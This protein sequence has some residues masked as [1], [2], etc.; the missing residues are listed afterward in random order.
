MPI[1]SFSCSSCG[2]EKDHL[3]KISQSVPFCPKCGSN[4]YKKQLTSASFSMG[5]QDKTACGADMKDIKE[6]GCGGNC[7]CHPH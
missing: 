7:A 3:L 2:F 1:Y 5:T 4:E 6:L